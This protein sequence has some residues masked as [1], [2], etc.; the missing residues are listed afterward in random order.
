[1]R[2]HSCALQNPSSRSLWEYSE[3]GCF[4]SSVEILV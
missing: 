2:H 3:V 4:S 1:M